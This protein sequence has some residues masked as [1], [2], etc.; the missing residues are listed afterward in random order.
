MSKDNNNSK[1]KT[2][3]VSSLMTLLIA[4]VSSYLTYYWGLSAQIRLNDYQSRQKV[5]SK[6]I[7]QNVI[8][9]QLY[10]SRFESFINSDFHEYRWK[11]E[12]SPKD[13]INQEEALRWMKKSEDQAIGLAREKQS[14]FET[15]GLI[16]ALFPYTKK[17]EE[18]SDK[19]YHHPIPHIKRSEEK[20][21]LEELSVYKET[22]VKQTQDFV[23]VNISNPIDELASYIKTQLHDDF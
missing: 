4:I 7:G 20:W 12:G 15:V 10:V 16:N 19:I 22:A 1:W 21:S 14:L 13:S 3:I 2:I 23:K 9:S 8:I 6:L 17:L 5:Y 11:L 18:L